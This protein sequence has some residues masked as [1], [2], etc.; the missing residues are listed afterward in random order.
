ML[1]TDRRRQSRAFG[2]KWKLLFK[3]SRKRTGGRGMQAGGE[4][5]VEGELCFQWNRLSSMFKSCWKECG[6]DYE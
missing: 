3:N 6:L 2:G 4:M 5:L 1:T